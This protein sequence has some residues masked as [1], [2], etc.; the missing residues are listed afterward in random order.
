MAITKKTVKAKIDTL[1][2]VNWSA[3]SKDGKNTVTSSKGFPV[4]DNPEYPN[5]EE[6]WLMDLAKANGGLV[7][8]T[9]Q[10][11]VFACSTDKAPKKLPAVKGFI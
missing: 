7:E 4:F 2:F 10:V 1:G 9:L 6:A 5:P 8:L 3:T 11:R